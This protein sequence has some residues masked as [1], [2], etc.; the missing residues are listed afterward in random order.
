MIA[1]EIKPPGFWEWVGDNIHDILSFLGIHV[2]L[3]VIA[4][5]VGVLIAFP[6]SI[7]AYRRPRSYPPLVWATGILYTIPSIALFIL[8]IPATGLSYLT[9]EVGL[10]MYTLLILLRN[11]VVGLRSVD[12]DVREAALGMGYSQR[13]ILWRVDVPLALPAIMAGIRL[14]TVSTIALVTVGF[15]IGK[16]AL[17]QLINTGIT[18]LFL[19]PVWVGV[20]LC[21][22]LA[23]VADALL[24]AL[25]RTLTPW[26]TSR[27]RTY[28]M[29][30]GSTWRKP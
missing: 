4:V 14:A 16:G 15:V 13:Q 23:L 21:I 5:T 28:A 25:G 27:P 24:L 30:R 20:L 3:A 11:F 1:Q 17:G 2:L 18:R 26:S 22:A 9:V 8:L 10:V 7:V 6:L 19:P 12:A 29:A